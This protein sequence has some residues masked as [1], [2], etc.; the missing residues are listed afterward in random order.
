MKR[1]TIANWY[2]TR[3]RRGAAG[4]GHQATEPLEV[5]RYLS[6]TP[7][8]AE[9]E[10]L[11]LINSL[12]TNPQGELNRLFSG[13]SPL[14]GRDANVDVSVRFFGTNAGI[15]ESQFASLVAV[16]PLAWN[17]ELAAAAETHNNLVVERQQQEHRFPGEAD[18]LERAIT[19]GYT[20]PQLVGEN[21][22]AFSESPLFGHAGLSVDW[23]D[24][25]SN[26][27]N[28]NGSGIQSPPGHRNNLMNPQFQEVGLSVIE[29]IP[30]TSAVGPQSVTQDFG[31][32]SNAGNAAVLGVVFTDSNTDSRYNAGEGLGG[33]AIEVS[34]PSGTFTTSTWSSGGYQVNVPAG[35][36][37]VKASGGGLG[38]ARTVSQITVG[39][40]HVKVDFNGGATNNLIVE[41]ARNRFSENGGPITFGTV[42]RTGDFAQPLVVSLASNDSNAA[43]VPGTVTIPAGASSVNFGV[44]SGS[45]AATQTVTFTATANGYASAGVDVV[46]S[47]LDG[48]EGSRLLRW[49]RGYNPNADYHFYTTRNFE[50]SNA[51]NA[52][53]LDE[54]TGQSGFAVLDRQV[55][56][57]TPV[58][59][60]YNLQTGRHYYTIFEGERDHLV[61]LVPPPPEG[62]PDTRTT[63]WRPEGV[64]GFMFGSAASGTDVVYKLYNR[65][66]G[67]HF[68]TIRKG[69]RDF[70]LANFPNVFEEHTAL[71]FAFPIDA[72]GALIAVAPP[73]A[74][75]AAASPS[76]A[77]ALADTTVG[78]D[79]ASD[80]VASLVA[81]T[82]RTVSTEPASP[83]RDAS[84]GE[85]RDDVRASRRRAASASDIV[86]AFSP[87]LDEVFVRMG[88]I[89]DV[90][91]DGD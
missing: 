71:G 62:Q 66:A 19:A 78:D 45:V 11:E 80:R 63:G 55:T 56:G 33:V 34:G 49:F 88:T 68:Y 43:G 70:V 14:R 28:G 60:L 83:P 64:E 35:T 4:C 65:V 84:H 26:P 24:N 31:R 69:E 38:A 2:A 75:A 27:A 17:V 81:P 72:D 54:A 90:V 3:R 7:T 82:V 18:L 58:Y 85:H 25:D 51:V 22:Y 87:E 36:Y 47:N 76:N 86:T 13:L 67:V 41:L 91:V 6:A 46:V 73:P 48:P 42:S 44:N 30:N 50:F 57:N 9:Q 89:T 10:T 20:N 39:N 59:R 61:N 12:R 16:P 8:P 37:T 29:G 79:S 21:I 23:G 32:R 5:R 53:Y 52:G 40:S 74:A 15:L 77:S 1:R